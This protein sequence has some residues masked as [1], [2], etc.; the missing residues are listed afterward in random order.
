M[1]M[2][3]TIIAIVVVLIVALGGY[4]WWLSRSAPQTA[5]AENA[6]GSASAGASGLTVTPVTTQSGS[7]QV[8]IGKSVQGRDITAYTFGQGT[9]SIM[10]VGGIHGG[11]EWNTVLLAY[12]LIDYLTANPRAVPANES[13]TVIPVVNPDGL[14]KVV[15]SAGRFSAADVPT[16]AGATVPGRFNANNVDLNRNFDCDWKAT[17]TWQNT[18]VSGGKSLFSEPESKAVRDYVELHHPTAVVVYYSA[19]GGVFASSCHNGVLAETKALTDLYAKAAG[20]P[21]YQSFDFYAT[22]GDMTN[23]LAVQNIPA[24]SVLLSNHSDT[25]WTKNLAGVRAVLASFAK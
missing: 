12:N 25:E 4:V 14:Y 13:V 10:F 3:K 8:I 20:Y 22:T 21:A 5:P 2:K 17:G 18:P 1:N 24:I 6:P 7:G 15:G 9:T 16:G 19:A 23:W 11:Y